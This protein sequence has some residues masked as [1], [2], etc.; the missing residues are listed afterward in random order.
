MSLTRKS[1]GGVAAVVFM[2][3]ASATA[4]EAIDNAPAERYA[5]T[6]QTRLIYLDTPYSKAHTE[7]TLLRNDCWRSG[8][9]SVCHQHVDGKPSA[10]LVYLRDAS[11]GGFVVYPIAREGGAVRPAALE[12]DSDTWTFPWQTGTGEDAI[13]FRVINRFR[14]ADEI[15]FREE[16]SH[17]GM[18]WSPMA[19]GSEHRVR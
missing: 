14:T 1:A 19:S 6:W 18:H 10:L 8:D 15:E 7:S 17:D 16:Y 3:C 13:H 11:A 2:L 4:S 9:F 5:G 12:V